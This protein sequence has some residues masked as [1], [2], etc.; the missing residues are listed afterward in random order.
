VQ[1]KRDLESAYEQVSTLL[2]HTIL[3]MSKIVELRDPY[4]AGRQQ[5]VA[6]L[7]VAIA[8]EL[9]LSGATVDQIHVAALVHDVGKMNIPAE[10][11]NRPGRLSA[12]E[13]T[14]LQ[15]HA[16][17]GY[18]IIRNIDRGGT[19]LHRGTDHLRRRC[20]RSHGQPPALPA[21]FGDRA[22]AGADL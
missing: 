17:S 5:R 9:G 7:A 1:G 18:E 13:R 6:A 21:G 19:D 15:T 12:L 2:A 3:A 22:R 8:Q 14:M 11:L 20:R 16:Q 4:T 10:I